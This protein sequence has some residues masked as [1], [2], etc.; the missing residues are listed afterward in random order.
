LLLR[1]FV[2]AYH[3]SAHLTIQAMVAMEDGLLARE[4]V[5]SQ[6]RTK[7]TF[8]FHLAENGF[9]KHAIWNATMS[10]WCYG[11]KCLCTYEN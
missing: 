5:D 6:R 1:S 9:S 3:T 4:V 8:E 2:R 11:Q 7:H 10:L